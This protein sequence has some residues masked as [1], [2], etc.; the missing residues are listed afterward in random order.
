MFNFIPDPAKALRELRR[1][2]KPGGTISAATWDYGDGMRM[3]R[4]FWDAAASLDSSAERLDERHMPLC[5]AGDLSQLWK[6]GGLEEVDE[7]PLDITMRFT[8]F[9]DYWDAF[10]LGQGP[11]GAYVR[12]L[13]R[14]QLQ[15]LRGEVKR[16]LPQSEGEGPFV[17]P[18]RAWSVRGTV[19]T[20]A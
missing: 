15:Q 10:L 11:A 9:A 6:Q 7:R 5:H 12:S 17:L 8:S 20:R 18:A 2:T 14:D 13:N 3:L 1:V 19:P 16:R 4:V